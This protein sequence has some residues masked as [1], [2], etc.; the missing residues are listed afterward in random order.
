MRKLFFLSIA[1][2]LLLVFPAAAQQDDDTAQEATNR[3]AYMGWIEELWREHNVPLWDTFVAPDFV[4]HADTGDMSS[5]ELLDSYKQNNIGL[6]PDLTTRWYDTLADADLVVS[7]FVIQG[8]CP[9]DPAFPNRACDWYGID[10]LR[11]RDGKLA[12]YWDT[13]DTLFAYRQW[14]FAPMD[15]PQP[16]VTAALVAARTESTL[17]RAESKALVEQA[18]DLFTG[19][20]ADSDPFAADVKV[21]LPLSLY[22]E[23]LELAGYRDV[24]AGY[25]AAFPGF[26]LTP[27]ED[28]APG[29]L[30]ADANLVAFA[31]NF[32]GTFSGALRG[33]EPLGSEVHYPGITIYRI[34]DGEIAEIWSVWDTFSELT[35][36]QPAET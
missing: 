28:I 25:Q 3:L 8:T 5:Q 2:C 33:I 21:H 30:A 19:K 29:G 35:Q 9:D 13:I 18:V 7:P 6:I 12:E 4:F 22:P 27:R 11:V 36:M 14:G 1:F 16:P 34:A 31:Y 17:S 15:G 24:M 26:T 32:R 20:S 10:T 23:A